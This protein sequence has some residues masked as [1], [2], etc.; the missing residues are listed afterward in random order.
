MAVKLRRYKPDTVAANEVIEIQ[1]HYYMLHGITASN[2]ILLVP[3]Q[4]EDKRE[5]P[6]DAVQ[7]KQEMYR[8]NNGTYI[9]IRRTSLV[10]E[11]MIIDVVTEINVSDDDDQQL[12]FAKG[13]KEKRPWHKRL[14]V[15]D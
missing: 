5:Q 8:L 12:L 10:I 1:A 9:K 3:E 7:H 13:M 11:P 15:D 4:W 6:L 14:E 2:L